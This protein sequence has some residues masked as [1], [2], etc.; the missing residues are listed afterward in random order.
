MVVIETADA[1]LVAHK[2]RAQEVKE[3]V[4]RLKAEGRPER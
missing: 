4:N 3:V 1:V 2:D